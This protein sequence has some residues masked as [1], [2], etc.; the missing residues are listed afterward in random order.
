MERYEARHTH[1]V[2]DEGVDTSQSV[3]SVLRSGN[4]EA[5]VGWEV[6]P[7]PW[8]W[9]YRVGLECPHCVGFWIGAGVVGS[10]YVAKQLGLLSLWRAGAGILSLNVVVAHGGSLIEY[11]GEKDGNGEED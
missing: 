9:K 1:P 8:W 2:Y 7:Q 6:D 11:Y 10:F 4:D 3:E 5:I